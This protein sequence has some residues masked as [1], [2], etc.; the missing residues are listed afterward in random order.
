MHASE[1]WGSDSPKA[2]LARLG[3]TPLSALYA[4]GWEGY[5]AM[6]RL[7]IKQAQEPHCPVLCVG[8]LVVGGAGKSPL[9]LHLAQLLRDMGREVVIGCSGYGGPHAEAAAL[10]PSGP[11]S[12]REWGDEP[13]MFRWLL[14]DVPLVVGRR[15]VLAAELVQR[16]HPNAVLV[17]DDGFQHLPV[18]KHVTLLLDEPNP[19]NSLCLPAGPYREPRWNRRRADEV[20]PGRFRVES[21]PL[22]IARPDGETVSPPV[23]YALLCALGQPQRFIEA[24]ESATRRAATPAIRLADHD[25]LDAG[26]LLER[27]PT[28]RPTIVTAKDWVKL[29]ER[30]DL[31]E[32]EWLI[33]RHSVRVEP[34]IEFRQW[35]D[36]KLDGRSSKTATE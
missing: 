31:G 9:T 15:R 27:L 11:L 28:D 17:M 35:L 24:V 18:R 23:E 8:N 34:A 20:L 1:L 36:A 7:G 3:L 19:K 32:R 14:P 33:A 16:S 25:P 26:T 5:L 13:A 2:K 22:C 29:R 4:L 6:Y 12:S 21:E 30:A 10:A